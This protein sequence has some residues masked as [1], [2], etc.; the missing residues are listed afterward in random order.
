VKAISKRRFSAKAASPHQSRH[1]ESTSTSSTPS[2]SDTARRLLHSSPSTSFRASPL[3]LTDAAVH[4]LPPRRKQPLSAV[5]DSSQDSSSGNVVQRETTNAPERYGAGSDTA[6]LRLR[7]SLEERNLANALELIKDMKA[8]GSYSILTQ[9]QQDGIDR[10]LTK[11]LIHRNNKK[12]VATVEADLVVELAHESLQQSSQPLVASLMY[13]ISHGRQDEV[14]SIY[15]TYT[16]MHEDVDGPTEGVLTE[17]EGITGLPGISQDGSVVSFPR[18]DLSLAVLAA[19]VTS[20]RLGEAL[21][22]FAASKVVLALDTQVV[23]RFTSEYLPLE[24]HR[25]LRIKLR[26]IVDKLSIARLILVPEFLK[27]QTGNGAAKQN[28]SALH[29]LYTRVTAG[30]HGP[31]SWIAATEAKKSRRRPIVLPQSVW[32]EFIFGFVHCGRGEAA[33]EVWDHMLKA[34]VEPGTECW[35]ALISAYGTSGDMDKCLGYF[36]AMKGQGLDPDAQTYRA[37]VHALF[38]NRSP[39]VAM[40]QYDEFLKVQDNFP[41]EDQVIVHNVALNGL[42]HHVKNNPR[43]EVEARGIFDNMRASGPKPDLRSYNTMLAY[44]GKRLNLKA[45]GDILRSLQED[46]LTGDVYTF[47]AILSAMLKAGRKDAQEI[48]LNVMK[49][50]GVKPNSATYTS[51]ITTQIADGSP[52][53]INAALELL[54]IMERDEDKNVHPNQVAY[55]AIISAISRSLKLSAIDKHIYT[56]DVLERMKHRHVVPNRTTLHI[57]MS[58]SLND[59]S[60]QGVQRALGYYTEMVQRRIH[61]V[62]D[63]WY[64]LLHGLVA[65]NEWETAREIVQ[66][67]EGAGFRADGALFNLVGKIRGKSKARP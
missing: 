53:S 28:Y 20:D 60:P 11:A 6:F 37:L 3:N 49:Q 34:G 66:D 4:P 45:C 31:D 17:T 12:T 18:P 67:M 64:I 51:I 61:M 1:D 14:I 19:Y 29:R 24:D 7:K 22:R 63:S 43:H 59:P 16:K 57:L 30:L 2:Q 33:A 50:Q 23:A 41:I 15:D 38:I 55:T 40:K 52:E 25:D 46:G 65:R 13:L 26:G 58:V 56:Q 32:S 21:D 9:A 39:I 36:D 44:Y 54:G 10:L 62:Q 47:S 27:N 48:M 35:N 8:Q 5:W 42:L